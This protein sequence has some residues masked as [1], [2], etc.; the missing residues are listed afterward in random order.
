MKKA[1]VQKRPAKV[2]TILKEGGRMRLRATDI[3]APLAWPKTTYPGDGIDHCGRV[4]GHWAVTLPCQ[5][6]PYIIR[7]LQRINHG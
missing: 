7:S 4:F 5:L 3:K 2:D 1:K 6:R